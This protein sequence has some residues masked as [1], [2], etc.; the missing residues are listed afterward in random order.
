MLQ[1]VLAIWLCLLG[2]AFADVAVEA[3]AFDPKLE[4]AE[5]G[6]L[7]GKSG[8]GTYQA[9]VRVRDAA[10]AVVRT[11]ADEARQR[12]QGYRDA[13][14]GRDEA[15]R[16]VAPGAY[17]VELRAA[18]QTERADVQ[19][20]RLGVVSIDFGGAGEVPLAF[21][22]PNPGVAGNPLP[23]EALGAVYT[24]PRSTLGDDCLDARDG[25]PLDLPGLWADVATPPRATDGSI[26]R[27]GRSLPVAYEVGARPALTLELGGSAAHDGRSVDCGYPIANV[28][29]RIKLNDEA[30]NAI[31]PGQRVRL[32]AGRLGDVV[33]AFRLDLELRFE[34]H[35]GTGWVPVPGRVLTQ[36]PLYVTLGQPVGTDQAWIAALDLVCAW[37]Y[38]ARDATNLLATTVSGLNTSLDLRYD[39]YQ[40]APA[41]TDVPYGSLAWPELDLGAF[42]DARLYGRT[43]NCLDCGSLVAA[44]GKQGGAECDV[45][46]LGW[47]FRL[48]YLKSIGSNRFGRDLFGGYHAFSYHA[49]ASADVATTILDACVRIDGDTRPD[50]PPF[51]EVLPDG[52][53]TAAYL[54]R[55]SEDTHAAPRERGQVM[56]R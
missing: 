9:V 5:L 28:P 7:T 38:G 55:L 47:D 8:Q 17:R 49:V 10:G 13:W 33:G 15:G 19:V 26:W 4:G 11:L 40:G 41:Y 23:L 31:R 29:L 44:L 1:R 6:V 39:S 21:H 35:D 52:I 18:G 53:D 56:V 30:S 50:M 20:V 48:H 54:S 14:D 51:Q 46:V 22:R 36:H 34:A 45:I 27:R 16:F 37:G 32:D 25:A 24:L 43:V 2:V 3:P 42:L 12:S